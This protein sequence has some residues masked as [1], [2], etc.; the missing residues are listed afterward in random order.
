MSSK[1]VLVLVLVL[2]SIA[3]CKKRSD[4]VDPATLPYRPYTFT[5]DGQPFRPRV[6]PI[7]GTPDRPLPGDLIAVGLHPDSNWHEL[8][9]MLGAERECHFLSATKEDG[10]LFLKKKGGGRR[11][12]GAWVEW[13]YPGATLIV[14]NPLD[15]LSSRQ[16]RGLWGVY[17]DEW[18]KGIEKQLS[19][20]SLDRACITASGRTARR[21][22]FPPIPAAA[23]CLLVHQD[24]AP[25]GLRQLT[26]L[27]RYRSL[28]AF[29][30]SVNGVSKL[31]LGLITANRGLQLLSLGVERLGSVDDLGEL[32]QLRHLNLAG[33][34]SVTSLG[35]ARKLRNLRRINV[36]ATPVEDLSPLKGLAQLNYVN[37]DWSKVKK[38]PSSFAPSL[39]TLRVMSTPLKERQVAALAK[40]QPKLALYH[41]WLTALRRALK[42]ADQ[43]IV[44]KRGTLGQDGVFFKVTG[45]RPTRRLISRLKIR[46][47][48]EGFHCLC[49]GNPVFE[50]RRGETLLATISWHHGVSVRWHDH[51]G[52]GWAGSDARL[53][54]ASSE[55]LGGLLK[56]NGV[57]RP[58]LG[59]PGRGD[60]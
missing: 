12:V 29:V 17:L 34:K 58:F 23:R 28:R 26:P 31:G 48:K 36:A 3:S 7:H 45:S 2:L 20:L 9:L 13:S 57:K 39:R 14:H 43:V 21:G 1:M 50:F 55:Y 41:R 53:T 51:G 22:S 19:Q 24:F 54:K 4:P 52:E 10:R 42:G 32:T 47:P 38:L 8:T 5:R 18:P 33:S 25:G 30:F 35:F 37:A 15:K 16:I 59:Q 11:L 49:S 46:E 27:K 60:E 40:R 6:I 44:R 56:A